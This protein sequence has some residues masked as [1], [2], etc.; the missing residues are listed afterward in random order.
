VL[1]DDPSG[2]LYRHAHDETSRFSR[3]ASPCQDEIG[4]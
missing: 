1:F 2:D 4:P 3:G